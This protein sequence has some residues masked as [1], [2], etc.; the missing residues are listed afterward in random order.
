M[1]PNANVAQVAKLN[2]E[3]P[4]EYSAILGVKTSYSYPTVWTIV[5]PEGTNNVKYWYNC[6][7]KSIVGNVVT[8]EVDAY[9]SNPAIKVDYNGLKSNWDAIVTNVVAK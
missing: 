2:H 5:V 8:I 6:T 7:I 3:L 1:F 9:I 4:Y